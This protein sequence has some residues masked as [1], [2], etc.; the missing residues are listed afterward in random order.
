MDHHAAQPRL[1]HRLDEVGFAPHYYDRCVR[2]VSRT[3]D[4]DPDRDAQ[5]RAIAG[6]G[7]AFTYDE[8]EDFF[9][10]G[11]ETDLGTVI[12]NVVI[13]WGS[14]ELGGYLS[15]DDGL[16]GGAFHV[17]ALKVAQLS[18]PDWRP[19]PPYPR[20]P[21]TDSAGLRAALDHGL[22]LHRELQDA[23][24]FVLAAPA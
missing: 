12:L 21:F 24:R 17:L 14:V 5:A 3:P 2:P 18:R 6:T 23:C 22:T 9:A 20:L 1:L 10:H 8:R 16:L 13:R 11:Q 19:E 4:L 7:L 15:R